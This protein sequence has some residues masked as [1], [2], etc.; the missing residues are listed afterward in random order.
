M[1]HDV[2]VHEVS[3]LIRDGCAGSLLG[4]LASANGFNNA[5]DTVDVDLNAHVEQ[6]VEHS[7]SELLVEGQDPAKKHAA[8]IAQ[9]ADVP[10]RSSNDIVARDRAS[11][12]A[13]VQG[14][15]SRKL[16]DIVD[17]SGTVGHLHRLSETFWTGQ[18]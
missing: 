10:Q 18:T 14:R 7:V 1:T 17:K 4:D 2:A 3:Q 8:C 9:V 12:P 5:F 6:H 13:S 11:A 15:V 16:M